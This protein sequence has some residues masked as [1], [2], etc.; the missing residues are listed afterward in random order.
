[1]T[2][3]MFESFNV[4]AYYVAI[5][6]VLTLYASGR[7]RGL[8]LDSGDG[9][10]HTVPVYEGYAMPHAVE[11]ANLAGR[12]LTHYLQKLLN[13]IGLDLKQSGELESVKK[14]KEDLCYIAKD[15]EAEM[16]KANQNSLPL[17]E[18]E[19]PDGQV[20]KLGSQLF[21]CP[22]ALFKPM[23]IGK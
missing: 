15:Y 8:V 9:V 11:R 18:F 20:I 4:P 19:L 1:M 21:R 16:A 12:D 23:D 13:E 2:E 14:I 3:I 10:T 7:T 6:A 5:Q 22:E 17:K